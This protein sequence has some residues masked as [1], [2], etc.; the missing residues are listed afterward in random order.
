MEDKKA[1][2]ITFG[3]L[4]LV[5]AVLIVLAWLLWS[6]EAPA[7]ELYPGQYAQVAP[8]IREWFKA[9]R[10]PGSHVPCC[11]EADGVFA[12]EDTSGG[13]YRVRFTYAPWTYPPGGPPHREEERDSG[14]MDV[15]DEAVIHAPNPNGAP[16]V[17]WAME[18]DKVWIRCYA[19]GAG[20]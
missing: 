11:S 3:I 15:P 1:L 13:H 4:G 9:Q 7:R 14:W 20:L 19:P 12:Q 17:W 5:Y 16:V 10:N 18:N 2:R 8:E 6:H